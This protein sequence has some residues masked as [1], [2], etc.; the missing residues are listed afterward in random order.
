M[1]SLLESELVLLE[2]HAAPIP[3]QSWIACRSKAG[4]ENAC[5]T[6]G[7]MLKYFVKRSSIAIVITTQSIPD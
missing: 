3:A 4:Y 7:F 1:V 5:T 2:G 6:N